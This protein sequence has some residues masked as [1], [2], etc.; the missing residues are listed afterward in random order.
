[1]AAADRR[2]EGAQVRDRDGTMRRRLDGPDGAMLYRE[3]K[4]AGRAV[5]SRALERYRHCAGE[6]PFFVQ[7]EEGQHLEACSASCIIRQASPQAAGRL[8]PSA[9]EA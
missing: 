5:S 4:P 6:D 2:R 7:R 3:E 1:M 8:N 9:T